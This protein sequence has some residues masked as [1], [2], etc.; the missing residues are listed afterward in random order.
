MTKIQM[1]LM[2][3]HKNRYWYLFDALNIK[4]EFSS[5]LKWH[6]SKIVE[7]QSLIKSLGECWCNLVIYMA[8]VAPQFPVAEK[9][10]HYQVLLEVV[11]SSPTRVIFSH[12][13][14]LN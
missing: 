11:G 8:W 6:Q 13:T 3:F 5:W 10:L 1:L 2:I 12:T 14:Y 4:N 7:N 9:V